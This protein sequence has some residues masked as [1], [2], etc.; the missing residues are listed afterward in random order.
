MRNVLK[1][2]LPLLLWIVVTVLVPYLQDNVFSMNLPLGTDKFVHA[3]VYFI[4][5]WLA[6]RSFYHQTAIP[7]LRRSSLLGA[8]IFSCVYGI[9]D[10]FHQVVLPGRS[11]N[12]YDVLAGVGGA[13][14]SVA[15]TSIISQRR[16]GGGPESEG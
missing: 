8:F 2:Q 7:P 11:S 10:E 6:Q 3:A 5:C 15:I 4:L 12:M 1:Y 9:L 14:L 13:L 16:S